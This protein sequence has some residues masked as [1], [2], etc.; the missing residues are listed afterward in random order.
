MTTLRFWPPSLMFSLFSHGLRY[1]APRFTCVCCK[2][3]LNLRIRLCT[4]M[5]RWW[6]KLFVCDFS[7]AM[8]LSWLLLSSPVTLSCTMWLSR[9]A[10]LMKLA[11]LYRVIKLKKRMLQPHSSYLLCAAALHDQLSTF[12]TQKVFVLV[13]TVL[14]WA[15]SK[16][17]DPVSCNNVFTLVSGQS[18]FQEEP[19][20]PF[21]EED[22]RRRRPH[23][24]FTAH[25]A[26]EKLVI[27]LGKT[28]RRL[29]RKLIGVW[30]QVGFYQF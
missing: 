12:T 8:V 1:Q 22:Y 5:N 18:L 16:P 26:A 15:R 28:V 14:T 3:G 7:G 24:N 20:V 27:K 23:P 10:R 4:H 9:L 11:L 6:W 13:S 19:D 21:Q 17:L 29:L 2:A 25:I 30:L